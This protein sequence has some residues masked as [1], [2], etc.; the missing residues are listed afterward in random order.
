MYNNYKYVP[1]VF[2]EMPSMYEDLTDFYKSL[3]IYRKDKNKTNWLNFRTQWENLF[4][5]I[6]HKEIEGF[7]NSTDA[8][9]M[10]DY[11]EEMAND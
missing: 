11:L 6:K 5:T 10:R 8:Q 2:K 9:E 1:D 4:F 7:L 3:E